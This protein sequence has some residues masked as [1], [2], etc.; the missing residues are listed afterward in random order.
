VPKNKRN[1]NSLTLA[2]ISKYFSMPIYFAAKEIGVGVKAL[3]KKCR[4]LNIECW[5]Y[6]KG[7]TIKILPK[8]ESAH[9]EPHQSDTLKRDEEVVIEILCKMLDDNKYS[10]PTTVLSGA[11][12]SHQTT[13]LLT[14]TEALSPISIPTKS[15]TSKF[16]CR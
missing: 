4:S 1:S 9:P 16:R 3:Q 7:K 2:E 5:P 15:I 6:R 8:R 14:T 12:T 11:E 10:M 13:Y